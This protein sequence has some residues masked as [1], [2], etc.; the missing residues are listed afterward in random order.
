[1]TLRSATLIAPSGWRQA[2]RSMLGVVVPRR[3]FL[4]NGPP[5][6]NAVCLTFDDGPDPEWTPKVLDRLKAARVR[7][8]F[9]LQ[10]SHAFAHPDLVRR[11]VAE[12]H[13]LGHHSWTHGSPS[14]TS[15]KELAEQTRRTQQWLRASI[16]VDSSLFRPP[17]GK[18]TA[19]KLLRSWLLG[20]TVVLWS[21]DPGDLLQPSSDALLEWMA[22]SPLQGGDIVLL[23]DRAPALESALPAMLDQIKAQGLEFATISEWLAPGRSVGS[24][25]SQDLL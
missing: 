23:H 18:L 2:A 13:E 10:G 19:A 3:W 15:A 11:I 25:V 12:G 14:Q 1:M 22:R 7:A 21:A 16:G 8:T 24:F 20:Q 4:V 9:F 5:A 6:T 17:H